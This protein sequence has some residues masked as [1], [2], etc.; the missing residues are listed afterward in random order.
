M[1]PGYTFG[2][3]VVVSRSIVERAEY[4]RDAGRFN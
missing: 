2:A 4:N 1:Q 3:S